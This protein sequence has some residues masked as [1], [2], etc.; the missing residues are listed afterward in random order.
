LHRFCVAE[1]F[2]IDIFTYQILGRYFE[3]EADMIAIKNC[4]IDE[5]Y[6]ALSMLNDIKKNKYTSAIF[7][8][9]LRF[10][11]VHLT[12]TQRIK[13]IKTEITKRKHNIYQNA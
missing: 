13:L 6:Y 12:E 9:I 8:K 1:N 4:S 2:I 7:E 3:H 11:D 5:L 10:I